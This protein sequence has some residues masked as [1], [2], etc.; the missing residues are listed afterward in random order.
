MLLRLLKNY[1][2]RLLPFLSFRGGSSKAS[3]SGLLNKFVYLRSSILCLLIYLLMDLVL[4]M[5]PMMRFMVFA[6]GAGSRWDM[7]VKFPCLWDKSLVS[8]ILSMMV[9][10]LWTFWV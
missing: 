10:F 8:D 2:F 4:W 3:P 7:V 1:Q 9:G 5:M 6:V